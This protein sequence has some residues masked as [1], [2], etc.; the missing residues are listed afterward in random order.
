MLC[1][2]LARCVLPAVALVAALAPAAAH[3]DPLVAPGAPGQFA[4]WT[5]ANKQGFGISVNTTSKVWQ[6]LQGGELIEVYYL[7]LGTSAVRDLQLIVTDGKTFTD[8]ETD[9]TIQHVQLVDKRS[10]TYR[11]VNTAKSGRYR[12]TKTYVTD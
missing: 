2:S 6:T 8:R 5:L 1:L 4:F 3:A 9:D 12:I 11:Q 10:F 7:D